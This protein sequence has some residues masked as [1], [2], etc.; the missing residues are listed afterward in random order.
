MKF[1]TAAVTLIFAAS[2]VSGAALGG[3]LAEKAF[4]DDADFGLCIPTMKYEG[5]LGG[6]STAD[7]TFLPTDPLCARGQQEALN[8]SRFIPLRKCPQCH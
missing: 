8:P 7:F 1:E 6:R 4:K 3:R 2:S 5:A